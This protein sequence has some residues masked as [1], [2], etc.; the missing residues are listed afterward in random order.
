[1]IDAAAVSKKV[2][3]FLYSAVDATRLGRGHDLIDYL[4]PN[5]WRKLNALLPIPSKDITNG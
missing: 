2:V 5:P 3:E 4:A 1:M